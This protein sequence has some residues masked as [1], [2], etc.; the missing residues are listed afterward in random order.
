MRD[1]IVKE[2]IDD[3]TLNKIEEFLIQS[4]VGIQASEEIKNIIAQE[5]IDL[6]KNI[7]NEVNIILKN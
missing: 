7:M 1:I 2:E 6:K 4:D 3:E 5:K